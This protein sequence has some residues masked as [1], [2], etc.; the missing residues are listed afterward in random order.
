MNSAPSP[1]PALTPRPIATTRAAAAICVTAAL[2]MAFFAAVPLERFPHSGDEYAYQYQARTFLAGRV[3]NPPA[4]DPVAYEQVHIISTRG[5]CTPSTRPG[6][7]RCSPPARRLA[8]DSWSTRSSPRSR[9]GP[10]F[11]SP[12][13]SPATPSRWRSSLLLATNGFFLLN[14]ATFFSHPLVGLALVLGLDALRRYHE[15]PRAR[16]TLA[17]GA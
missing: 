8:S 1:S 16:H 10:R 12:G 4:P 15:A 13:A 3:T 5:G 9:C 6:G 7:P 11:A 17:A 14:G 2:L